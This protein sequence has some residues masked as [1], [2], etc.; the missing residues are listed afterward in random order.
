MI[1]QRLPTGRVLSRLGV[2]A[3][4]S[5]LL[6]SPVACNSS[7]GGGGGSPTDPGDGP[8][9]FQGEVASVATGDTLVL[10]GG[11]RIVISED[12]VFD[13]EGDLF[14]VDTVGAALLRGETVTAAGT[15]E[16]RTADILEA[17]E[18]R[19]DSSAAGRPVQFAGVV[20]TLNRT[21]GVITLRSG[22]VLVLDGDT[23]FDPAGDATSFSQVVAAF[24]RGDRISVEGRGVL[25]G[26]GSARVEE[27]AVELDS[28]AGGDTR[29]AGVVGTVDR[30]GRRMTL[31]NGVTVAVDAATRFDATGDL[32]TFEAVASAVEQGQRIRV[33]GDG[34]FRADGSVLA[35]R[36]RAVIEVF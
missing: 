9:A 27:I 19:L 33:D 30:G 8:V 20:A 36:I 21:Q 25:R 2:F 31:T 1:V 28:S 29:F 4:W 18:I 32:F 23:E 6:V 35:E 15:G 34:M 5:S 7:G 16:R 24:D 17:L 12:T 3:L 26:D 13:P 22:T 14:S 10:V 11:L